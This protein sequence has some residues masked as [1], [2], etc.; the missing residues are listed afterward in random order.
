MYNH[1]KAIRYYDGIIITHGTDTSAYTAAFLSFVLKGIKVPIMLVSAD[2]PL[3]DIRSNGLNNFTAAVNFIE[4]VGTKGVFVPFEK[5]GQTN[6]HLGTRL[7]QTQPFCHNCY[8]M[9]GVVYGQMKNGV[10]VWNQ[11]TH[12]P[13]P[14]DIEIEIRTIKFPDEKK[15]LYLEEYPGNDYSFFK[16]NSLF[17]HKNKPDAVLYG[18]Y[19]SGTA[20]AEKI[21]EFT[22]N[23]NGI[24]FYAAP[25]DSRNAQYSTSKL[26]E[27]AGI[28]F[29]KDMSCVSAYVKLLVAYGSFT[30]EFVRQK[31][32][33]TTIACERFFNST[34][35]SF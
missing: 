21:I 35:N 1:I 20:H 13:M 18:L 33:D 9:G 10:F 19:H 4:K 32:I 29:I 16:L 11:H 3:S 6:I 12:N 26:M 30:D 24:D 7:L 5:N 25:Y 14:Q 31:F 15:I 8:S 34:G 17:K 27:D 22:K 2:Y 23:Y 28:K